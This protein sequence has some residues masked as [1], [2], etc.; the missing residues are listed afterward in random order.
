MVMKII[1]GL[2][3]KTRRFEQA[4]FLKEERVTVMGG[5][6]VIIQNYK[7]LLFITDTEVFLSNLKIT[8]NNLKVTTLSQYVMEVE[9]NVS[10]ITF[11]GDRHA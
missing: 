9:G 7:D 3:Q 10:G 4:F 11:M 5:R 2:L 1:R 6:K 8:G